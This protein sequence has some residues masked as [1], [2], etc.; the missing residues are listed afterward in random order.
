MHDNKQGIPTPNKNNTTISK[1]STTISPPTCDLLS[2]ATKAPAHTQLHLI[3]QNS[4]AANI[5]V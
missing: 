3:E 5:N 4:L 1:E 2:A